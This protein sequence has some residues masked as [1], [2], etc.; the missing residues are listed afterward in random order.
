VIVFVFGGVA[1]SGRDL[2]TAALLSAGQQV[3][4]ACSRLRLR[5]RRVRN[6]LSTGS[7]VARVPLVM[8]VNLSVPAK[9]G[10]EFIA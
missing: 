5:A 9:T 4:E 2:T 3:Y 6:S 7:L 10:P 1:D 8:E